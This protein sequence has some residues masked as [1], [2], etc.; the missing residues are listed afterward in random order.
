MTALLARRRFPTH[1]QDRKRTSRIVERRNSDDEKS[2]RL[3]KTARGRIL[4][5]DL[6]RQRTSL[7]M[8]RVRDEAPSAAASTLRRVE[9][10]RVDRV[11]TEPEEPDECI[12]GVDE[13]WRSP[14][15]PARLRS[16]RRN[17]RT[18]S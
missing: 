12:R 15:R 17:R 2:E 3:V 14:R 1:S 5:V 7:E 6:D 11:V 9:K 10:Q 4:F 18:G 8:L 16:R 13:S